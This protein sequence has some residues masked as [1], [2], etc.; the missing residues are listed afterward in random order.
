MAEPEGPTR[1]QADAAARG[2]SITVRQRPPAK[3]IEEAA[4]LQGITTADIA[5]TI[6]MRAGTGKYLFAIVPGNRSVSFPALRGL[7]GVSKLKFPDAGEVL[8]AVGYERGTI[9]PLGSKHPYPAYV[10][11][12]LS[13][14]TISMGSGTHGFSILVAVDDL[15]RGLDATVAAIAS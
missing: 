8:E 7:L 6:V 5:K 11:E 12:S 14:R 2:I 10:D 9:T 15:V 4:A 3:S 13:G 1:A